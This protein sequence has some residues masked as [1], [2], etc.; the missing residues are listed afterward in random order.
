MQRLIEQ[1][2]GQLGEFVEQRDDLLLCLRSSDDDTAVAL[3]VLRDLEQASEHDVYLLFGDDFIRGPEFVTALIGHVAE[4]REHANQCLLEEGKTPLPVIPGE[5]LDVRVDPSR[6]LIGAIEYAR[7][8]LPSGGGHRLVW[9]M[10]PQQI[11]DRRQ[12]LDLVASLVPHGGVQPWMRGVRV[13]F[14][15][16]GSVSEPAPDLSRAPRT[17]LVQVDFSPPALEACAR[18][19]VGD[20]SLP[21]ES[22][23]Q[24]LLTVASLDYAHGRTQEAIANYRH[25]LGYYQHT[26]NLTMQA[27]VLHGLGDVCRRADMTEDALYWYECAAVP[28]GECDAPVVLA[29]VTRSLGQLSYELGRYADAEQ[30]FDGLDALSGRLLDA[31][32]KAYALEWKGLSR[33]RQ[34]NVSGAVEAWETAA[35]LCRNVGMSAPLR[36]VLGRLRG[37]YQDVGM[38]EQAAALGKELDA[39]PTTEQG[40]WA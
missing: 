1:L 23:M 37:L 24:A 13:V 4:Q 18:E 7:A 20:E 39:T 19:D 30:Y 6:R 29:I 40:A 9:A 5:L 28:A 33:L 17:R 2:K 12:W 27:L 32:S 21:V 34:D 25:L 22:R 11:E 38:T 3:K 10:V 31:E 26:E 16:P 35:K 14:R 8:L 15:E 36:N